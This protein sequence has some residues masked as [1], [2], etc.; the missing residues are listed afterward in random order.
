[1]LLLYGSSS[2]EGAVYFNALIVWFQQLE[3][4]VYFNASLVWFQQLEG[5]VY[6]N[7]S[8]VWF[9]QLEGAVYFNASIGWFQQCAF[10]CPDHC[11]YGRREVKKT[12]TNTLYFIPHVY[13]TAPHYTKKFSTTKFITYK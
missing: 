5:A 11:T 7:D 12:F 10:N 9:Q 3:R 4:A 2:I 1:M 13:C 8:I 6:F